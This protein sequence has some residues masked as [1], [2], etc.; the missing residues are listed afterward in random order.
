M[1][2]FTHLLVGILTAFLYNPEYLI[3]F[4]LASTFPDLDVLFNHRRT[5]HAPNIYAISGIILLPLS[6]PAALFL[7]LASLH[8]FLDMFGG[9]GIKPWE[10]E[11]AVYDHIRGKYIK[12]KI[13]IYDGSKG[14]FAILAFLSAGTIYYSSGIIIYITIIS[15]TLGFIYTFFRNMFSDILEDKK[16]EVLFK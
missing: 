7:L 1:M 6:E 9:L 15:I 12:S 8:C 14:D 16:Y 3:L 5:L 4:V 2:F 10:C 13:G 11:K